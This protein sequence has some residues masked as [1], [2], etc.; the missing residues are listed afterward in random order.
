MLE[1]TTVEEGVSL[2][3]YQIGLY[4]GVAV[5]SLLGDT[6]LDFMTFQ[7]SCSNVLIS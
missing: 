4:V 6:R 5:V 2:G 7:R 1:N 3:L